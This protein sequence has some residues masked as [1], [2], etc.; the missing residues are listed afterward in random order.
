[1]IFFFLHYI[2]K[3]ADFMVS[4]KVRF[5]FNSGSALHVD[6][7]TWRILISIALPRS[8]EKEKETLLKS[9]SSID[10][11]DK[12]VPPPILTLHIYPQICL[13]LSSQPLKP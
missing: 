1:M 11:P 2:T 6:V 9:A 8:R 5:R 12:Y 3:I 13:P 4:S 10:N 7:P